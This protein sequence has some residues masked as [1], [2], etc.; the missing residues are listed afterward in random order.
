MKKIKKLPKI[1]S[2]KKLAFGL[3]FFPPIFFNRIRIVK[4]NQSF[5]KLKVAVKYSWVN[6]NIQKAIFGGTIFSAFDPYFAVM[7]WQAFTKMKIPMEVWVKKVQI[8]YKKPAKSDL[9][10]IFNLSDQDIQKAIKQ[11]KMDHKYEVSHKAQAFDKE[12]DVCAEAEILI[13]IR[14][15]N[16]FDISYL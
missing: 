10:I 8:T 16:K 6:K 9:S 15:H 7:Y 5:T 13:H 3:N 14:N 2:A 1:Y 4:V 11:L 12:G